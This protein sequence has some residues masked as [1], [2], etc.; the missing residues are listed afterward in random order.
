M[1]ELPD[2]VRDLLEQAAEADE[3]TA[4]D[5]TRVHAALVA[6]IASG[7]AAG[8]A[9][10]SAAKASAA[11]TTAGGA[12]G[13]SAG[14]GSTL[15]AGGALKWGAGILV[16][17]AIGTAAMVA[18]PAA[19]PAARPVT[20]TA[21]AP[22]QPAPVA[23]PLPVVEPLPVAEPAEP[24]PA[25]ELEPLP[26]AEPT[27]PSAL[28]TRKPARRARARA[29]QSVDADTP[30]APSGQ[31]MQ[32][33]SARAELSLIQRATHA[34]SNDR[35]ARALAKLREH[36]RR[37]PA[38]V[39]TQERLALRVLTLCK[40]GRLEQGRAERAAFLAQHGGS[41]LAERVRGACGTPAP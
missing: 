34:L 13:A 12:G 41:P 7:A 26:I 10:G 4:A 2:Q 21:A 32:P 8:A 37:F 17:A 23:E 29:E 24:A 18:R 14:A 20:P 38:G 11:A 9:G 27:E 1:A 28:R 5:R 15:A 3:P 33:P 6:A 35:P 16:A 40:L 25:A 22:A 31:A 30:L 36:A 39:L 19:E